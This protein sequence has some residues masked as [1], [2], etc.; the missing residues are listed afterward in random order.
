MAF[1][2]DPA[3]ITA[4]DLAR[5]TASIDA[6]ILQAAETDQQIADAVRDQEHANDDATRAFL[7][8]RELCLRQLLTSLSGELASLR[9]EVVELLN[10]QRYERV[11]AMNLSQ[12]QHRTFHSLR[13]SPLQRVQKSVC[14]VMLFM[15]LVSTSSCAFFV[16]Y[17]YA[18]S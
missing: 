7:R 14:Y 4:S 3:A 8:R 1:V 2:A 13:F 16:S 10:L 5:A 12:R 18:F 6:V 9:A 15:M 17:P 11:E